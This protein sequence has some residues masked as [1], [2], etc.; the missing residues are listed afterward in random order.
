MLSKF[1]HFI[2]L[3]HL[4]SATAIAAALVTKEIMGLD[5]FLYSIVLD[6]D[7]VFLNDFWR[8]LFRL[9]DTSLQKST[10]YHPLTHCQLEV[11]NGCLE[12]Y[13]PCFSSEKPKTGSC[14]LPWAE[15]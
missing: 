14:W 1:S 4:Y 15:Y 5:R 7:N 2:P 12:S 8:E 13:L 9:R 6:R 10:E 3:K 11:V